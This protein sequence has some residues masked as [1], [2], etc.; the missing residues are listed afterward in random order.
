M[1][2]AEAQAGV[3]I[4]CFLVA[5]IIVAPFWYHKVRQVR[6]QRA[7]LEPA[8]LDAGESATAGPIEPRLED[9]VAEIERSAGEGSDTTARILV[10]PGVTVDGRAVPPDLVDT[11]VRDALRRSALVATAELDTPE[12]RIIECR[13]V[14]PSS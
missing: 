14:E 8:V 7:A 4:P 3:L 13:R 1:V 9:V 6:E 11:L 5:G 10:P 2:M 12:G